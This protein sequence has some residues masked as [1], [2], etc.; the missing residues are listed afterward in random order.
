[1]ITS[2]KSP[3]NHE[4]SQKIDL[5]NHPS[6]A[7]WFGTT[8]G[9]RS[10]NVICQVPGLS[11]WLVAHLGSKRC[12]FRSNDIWQP[13]LGSASNRVF[14]MEPPTFRQNRRSRIKK[15]MNTRPPGGV[16]QNW[17]VS[18]EWTFLSV[19]RRTPPGG[20]KC[21]RRKIYKPTFLFQPKSE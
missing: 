8:T 21:D 11:S 16:T 4:T 2:N 13:A 12:S 19:G 6:G 14:I 7:V 10:R 9:M 17:Y 1:M 20:G 18:R 3:N 15:G 5:A